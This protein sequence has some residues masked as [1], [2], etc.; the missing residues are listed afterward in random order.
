M[1]KETKRVPVRILVVTET[2]REW[3]LVERYREGGGKEVSKMF[4]RF[5]KEGDAEVVFC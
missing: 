4:L 2:F 1:Q 3:L 5:V